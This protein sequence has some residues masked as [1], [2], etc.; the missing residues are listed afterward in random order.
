[1]NESSHVIALL[2][3]LIVVEYDA[4]GAYEAA[5]HRVHNQGLRRQLQAFRDD[6]E[7]HIHELAGYVRDLGGQPANHGDL[8]RLFV[9][10]K[11][12]FGNVAGDGGIMAAMRSNEDDVHEIYER[13]STTTGLPQH[14]RRLLIQHL[15]DERRH[16][17]WVEDRVEERHP[18]TVPPPMCEPY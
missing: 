16:S 1:M 9:K 6:H 8:K 7:R 3:E 15:S 14:V 18:S 11:V 13:A 12:L 5:I 17:G 2:N 4:V 10:G